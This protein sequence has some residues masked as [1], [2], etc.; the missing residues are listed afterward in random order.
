[1]LIGIII[2][3]IPFI[4]CL[5]ILDGRYKVLKEQSIKDSVKTGKYIEKELVTTNKDLKK[6]DIISETDLVG[7]DSYIDESVKTIKKENVIGKELKINVSKGVLVNMDMLVEGEK[8][9]DDFRLHMLSDVELHSEI[10]DG[11]MVDIRISFPNGEDYVLVSGKRVKARIDD[12]IFIYVS[13][14]E[15]LK[16]S[17]ANIDKSIYKGANIYAILYVKDYQKAA[18]SNYPANLSVIELGNWN[19]NLINK[20]FTEDVVNKRMVLEEHLSQISEKEME[21]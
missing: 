3:A 21:K 20:V 18:I 19:P 4:V 7:I 8:I 10:V 9:P 6:G 16:L 15:I 13:E 1:M 5:F 14:E 12:K 2:G 11:S 17:S